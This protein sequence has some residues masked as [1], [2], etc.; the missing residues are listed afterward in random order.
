MPR[1]MLGEEM[2]RAERARKADD[3]FRERL[4]GYMAVTGRSLTDLAMIVGISPATMY[5]RYKEPGK[6]RLVEYRRIMEE[7]DHVQVGSM[8]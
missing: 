6:L 2:R 1:I 7:L 8:R 4:G 5:N 3:A